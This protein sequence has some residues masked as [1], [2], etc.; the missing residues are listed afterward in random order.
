[1]RSYEMKDFLIDSGFSAESL[2]DELVQA[3]SDAEGV[4]NFKHI[5][6]MHDIRLPR[7]EE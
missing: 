5:A 4:E 2:L 6:N 3:M 7:E 1:M